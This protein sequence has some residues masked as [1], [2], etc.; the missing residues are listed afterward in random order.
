MRLHQELVMPMLYSEL[1][2]P[3][4]SVPQIPHTRWTER[5]PTGSS[6]FALS[7]AITEITTMIPAIRPMIIELST[8]TT[9]A[10]AV[11]PTKPASEP[12]RAIERSGFLV[13]IQEVRIAPIIPAAAAIQVVTRTKETP[14]ASADSTEPPLNPNQPNHRRNTPIAARGML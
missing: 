1:K 7:K 13:T 11:I 6:I 14:S 5:A 8:E 9:S 4:A 3:T 2:I 12:L 10:P